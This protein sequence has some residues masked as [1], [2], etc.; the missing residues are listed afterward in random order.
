LV[1]VNAT[2]G[3]GT[4]PAD[5]IGLNTAVYDGYMNDTPIP[6]LLTASGIGAMRY[7]GRVALADRRRRAARAVSGLVVAQKG[8]S[9]AR[10][11]PL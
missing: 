4:I 6:R 9:E 8:G 10:R 7:P 2:S 3:L 1:T 5:G 11:K